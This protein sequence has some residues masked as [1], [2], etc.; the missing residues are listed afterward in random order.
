MVD[1][2]VNLTQEKYNSCYR[3]LMDYHFKDSKIN[4]EVFLDHLK[5][6]KVGIDKSKML[7]SIN[8]KD[9]E[10]FEQYLKHIKLEYVR[11][12]DYCNGSF[13]MMNQSK[14]Y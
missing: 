11:L 12:E 9:I 10:V 5:K 13:L 1:Y 7:F 4:V 3:T 8:E 14:K 2:V 6:D